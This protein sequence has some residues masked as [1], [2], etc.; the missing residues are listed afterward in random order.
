[1]ARIAAASPPATSGV[2]NWLAPSELAADSVE[3]AALWEPELELEAEFDD[4]GFDEAD[5]LVGNAVEFSLE[6]DA[7]ELAFT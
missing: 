3:E 7:V 1:M 6:G 4:I 5:A 2:L